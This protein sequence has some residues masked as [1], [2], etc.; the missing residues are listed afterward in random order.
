[1][2]QSVMHLAAITMTMTTAFQQQPQGRA[3]PTKLYADISEWRDIMFENQPDLSDS[4]RR[5]EGL[6][7]SESSLD[8]KD[9]ED[10]NDG[11]DVGN[12]QQQTPL[13][14]ICVLPFLSL[15]HI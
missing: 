2:R 13:R 4:P 12:D 14:Q 11:D 6:T 1:M 10:E 15:I 7:L 9:N 5:K 3:W 8:E